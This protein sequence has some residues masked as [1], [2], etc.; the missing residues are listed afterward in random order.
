MYMNL[1]GFFLFYLFLS[2]FFSLFLFLGGAVAKH[3]LQDQ[4][5]D[6]IIIISEGC[7]NDGTVSG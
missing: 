1:G 6:K 2:P 7:N 4:H 5:G 3:L